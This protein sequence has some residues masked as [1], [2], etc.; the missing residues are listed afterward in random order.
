M[1][2]VMERRRHR[3]FGIATRVP[4]RRL[5]LDPFDEVFDSIDIS[6]GGVLLVVGRRIA[7]GD[8]LELR[9]GRDDLQV[10]LRGL[11]VA[12]RPVDGRPSHHYAHVAFTG[13]TPERRDS[14][15]R[16]LDAWAADQLA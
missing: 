13:L 15:Y 9:L 10:P 4:T 11:V 14:L 8:V 16:F 6:A 5:G 12:V 1:D 7:A 2:E 3:R